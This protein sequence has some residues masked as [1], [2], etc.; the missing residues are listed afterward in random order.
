MLHGLKTR[1]N[2]KIALDIVW[3]LVAAWGIILRLRQ[4]I[5]DRSLWLDEANLALNIVGRSFTGLT[6]PLDFEQGAPL[7][8]LFIE[9]AMILIFGNRDYILRFFPAISGLISV[10]LF[11]RICKEYFGTPGLFALFFFGVSSSLIYYSND[12]KQYSSDVLISTGLIYLGFRALQKDAG[13]REVLILGAAGVISLWVSYP[14]VFVLASIGLVMLIEALSRKAFSMFFWILGMAVVWA[15]NLGVTYLVSLR[16]LTDKTYLLNFWRQSFMPF[17]PHKNWF[18]AT[19]L[20]FLRFVAY[21]GTQPFWYFILASSILLIFGLVWFLTKD[22]RTSL[23]IVLP[24]V[25]TLLAS[26]LQKYPF[27]DRLILFLI[28]CLL[29]LMSKGLGQ[30]YLFLVRWNRTAALIACVFIA[31]VVLWQPA[32]VSYHDFLSPYTARKSDRSWIISISILNPATLFMFI[33]EVSRGLSIMPHSSILTTI[34]L[35]S[36]LKGTPILM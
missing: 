15:A 9:K 29:L 23:M 10:Y 35:S 12:L 2:S 3:W 34:K 4:Y 17:P 16:Y 36:V 31:L 18:V 14:S 28:P 22:R 24:F 21:I 13:L 33:M 6:Q 32:F 20:G 26:A 11:Y 30:I 25:F 19:Y 5:A 1:F 8:F 27:K 7:G